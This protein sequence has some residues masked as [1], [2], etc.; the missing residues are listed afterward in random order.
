MWTEGVQLVNSRTTARILDM[1]TKAPPNG[2]HSYAGCRP[3]GSRG[4]QAQKQRARHRGNRWPRQRSSPVLPARTARTW[5]SSD[6]K[7]A[8][9]GHGIK[10][11]ASLFNTERV[12]HIYQDP[13][14][15]N[16]HFDLH[17]GDLIDA[18]NLTGIINKTHS[19]IKPMVVEPCVCV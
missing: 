2:Q 16:G 5:R 7:W 9:R 15:P 11:R 13:H 19:S 3:A 4:S 12:D 6:R 14:T 10:R 1:N 18:S 8:T 17:D